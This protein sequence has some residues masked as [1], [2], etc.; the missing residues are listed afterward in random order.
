MP[1]AA[2]HIVATTSI[3]S[4]F[5]PKYLKNEPSP[6][7]FVFYAALGSLLPD[8]DIPLGWFLGSIGLVFDHGT[9]TH[10][11][12]FAFF[13][14]LLSLLFSILKK[15]G[16]S[17]AFS[18]FFF[19]ILIHLVL[20]F[21]LGGGAKEGIAWFYPFSNTA[22]KIHIL[23]LLPFDSTFEALDAI[24]L[25]FFFYINS[26]ALLRIFKRQPLTKPE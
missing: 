22:Y 14:L 23:F 24:V 4:R 15:R 8:I 16:L 20:D 11:P 21:V 1:L 2:T 7:Y 25:L 26:S 9:V 3:I 10:T 19:G 5:W 13:F 12:L 17:Q 6:R 18:I